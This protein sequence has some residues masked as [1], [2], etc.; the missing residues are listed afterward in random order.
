[1]LAWTLNTNA[2]N[3]SSSL[4]GGS[5]DVE[6]GDGGGDRSTM[7][8]SNSPTP[9]LVMADPTN[10]GDCSPARNS[11]RSTSPA[12]SSSSETSSAAAVQ[13]SPSSAAAR[14]G[15]DDLLDGLGRTGPCGRSARTRPCAG[16]SG[17]EV[18]RSRPAR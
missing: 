1:M 10:T 5:V 4:L 11:S 7:P 9:K 12:S 13:A 18:A 17:L 16:R 2:E 6:A 14:L 8:S 3:G 15:V